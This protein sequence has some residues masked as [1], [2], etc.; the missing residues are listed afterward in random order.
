MFKNTNINQGRLLFTS[1]TARRLDYLFLNQN[2]NPLLIKTEMLPFASTDH[3]AVIAIFKTDDFSRGRGFWKLNES[4]LDIPLFLNSMI[5]FITSH[6]EELSNDP[7]LTK[8]DIWELLKI[9]IR[10]EC[11]AFSRSLRL[12]SLNNEKS[13]IQLQELSSE[14]ASDPNNI[15]LINKL[16]FLTSKKEIFE[17]SESNGALKRAKLR[18]IEEFEKNSPLFLGLERSK[19]TQQTIKEINN[20]E[21]VTVST[22]G[23]ILK[24]LSSFYEDLMNDNF[25]LNLQ[26][27]DQDDFLNTFLE[28]TQFPTLQ[29]D[30][31]LLLDS[32][33][34]ID[35][36]N[37]A[38]KRLNFDSSPGSDGLSPIFYITFWKEL[39]KPLFE[40]FIESVEKESLTISQRRAILTLLPK[41][42]DR[43]LLKNVS[44]YRPIS[45]TNTDYKIY[46][47]I[48]AM[49][50]Q[51]VLK[52]IINTN[53]VGYIVGRS[54]NNHI[55]L[56]DDIISIT[57][58]ENYVY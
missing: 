46:S 49:R 44:H 57:N 45:L 18:Y 37:I 5:E 58:N 21:G 28:G 40:S 43:N 3:K 2:T 20:K 23:K 50:M 6:H 4:L 22:P 16:A 9:G 29:D 15:E 25:N 17:L 56:I 51:T 7:D 39:K 42:K 33:L 24:E 48:L 52:K 55:R 47:K 36:V 30:E 35:E 38:L 41:S 27:S 10:D 54:I 31:K 53:Q 14:L 13:N 34:S 32:P 26:D 8:G 11:I 1:C 12:K 19:Q